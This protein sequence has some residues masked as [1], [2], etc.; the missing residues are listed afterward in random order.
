MIYLDC[1]TVSGDHVLQ[2]L[3]RKTAAPFGLQAGGLSVLEVSRLM[4]S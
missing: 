4:V 1:A 3:G 2:Y